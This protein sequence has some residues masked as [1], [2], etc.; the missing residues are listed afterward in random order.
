MTTFRQDKKTNQL[1]DFLNK[2]K[3]V[4]DYA[5]IKGEGIITKEISRRALNMLEVDEIGLDKDSDIRFGI[6]GVRTKIIFEKLFGIDDE[7]VD[8]INMA[9]PVIEYSPRNEHYFISAAYLKELDHSSVDGMLYV[10]VG[11]KF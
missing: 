10:D 1:S 8:V 9:G 3:T 4:R 5:Q 6:E 2:T 11:F 7:D